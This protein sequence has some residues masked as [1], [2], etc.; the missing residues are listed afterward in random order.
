MTA[1]AAVMERSLRE[2]L[3]TAAAGLVGPCGRGPCG[4]TVH[5]VTAHPR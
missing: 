3:L 4:F 1:P 5:V 2:A